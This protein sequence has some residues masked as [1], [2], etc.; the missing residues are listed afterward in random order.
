VL[1]EARYGQTGG[2]WLLGI[3]VVSGVRSEIAL[4]DAGARN[5]PGIVDGFA[6]YPAGAP[7]IW[8]S[9]ERQRLGDRIGETV[10]VSP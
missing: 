4:S 5:V 3:R 1:L 7:F 2:T 10:V 9:D 8:L 6:C